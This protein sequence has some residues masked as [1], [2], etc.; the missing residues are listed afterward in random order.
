MK[1]IEVFKRRSGRGYVTQ[2]WLKLQEAQQFVADNKDNWEKFCVLH[3]NNGGIHSYDVHFQVV[4][5][6]KQPLHI[7]IKK[8]QRGFEENSFRVNIFST[9]QEQIDAE[10][11]SIWKIAWADGRF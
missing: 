7:T 2:D 6:P 11:T 8:E 5:V 9:T 4:F 1:K 3:K 10:C